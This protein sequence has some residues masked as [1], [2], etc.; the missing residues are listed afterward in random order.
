MPKDKH[1]EVPAEVTAYER[2]HALPALLGTPRQV[3][4][5][6]I[7][8]H[9]ALVEAGTK[10]FDV[11]CT[12]PDCQDIINEYDKLKNCVQSSRWIQ[13][14]RPHL[15]RFVEFLMELPSI[16]KAKITI[17][18]PTEGSERQLQWVNQIIS[19]LEEKYQAHL[20]ALT[21]DQLNQIGNREIQWWL[22]NRK[23][24]GLTLLRHAAGV[25][26]KPRFTYFQPI[27]Q[28]EK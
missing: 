22:S 25:Y 17:R 11:A 18:R 12:R 20:K 19:G 28:L 14:A 2:E 5:A 15:G 8:R 9:N 27:D 10:W 23:T 7:L 4:W 3:S 1:I 24:S 6:R 26:H 16:Q 13:E 21:A